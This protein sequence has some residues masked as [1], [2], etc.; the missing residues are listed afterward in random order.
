MTTETPAMTDLLR[1]GHPVIF[2]DGVCG[3]CNSFADAVLRRDKEALFRLAPLQGE[4]AKK[5]L[6]EAAE[7][8]LEWSVVYMDENGV[9]YRSTASL[10]IVKRLGGFW[11]GVAGV[12]LWV[13]ASI[14][15]AIYGVI[16]R[17]RYR[18]FGRKESCR[19]PR[20]HERAQFLD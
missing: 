7:D 14:R 12:L 5:L 18:W 6:G 2:F 8:P 13:P 3:L 1:H 9:H 15:D 16:A 10:R 17:N 4:T 11:G 20:P 19:I